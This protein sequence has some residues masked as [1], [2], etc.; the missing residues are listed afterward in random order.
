MEVPISQFRKNLF[1]LVDQAL[2]GKEIWV[3]H[4]GRRVRIAPEG[5]LPDKLSRITPMNVFPSGV[6]LEDDSWK[7][8]IMRTWEENWDRELARSSKA[9]TT[10]AAAPA[11]AGTRKTRR[12]A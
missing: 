5:P 6:D 9:I 11:R 10:P 12:K 8:E 2:E 4:K 7:E 1:A 3:R